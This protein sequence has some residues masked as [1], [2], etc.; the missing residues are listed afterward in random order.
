MTK[1]DLQTF[2][3]V[4]D[5]AQKAGIIAPDAMGLVYQARVSAINL[6][7]AMKDTDTVG[8]IPVDEGE[9]IQLPLGQTYRMPPKKTVQDIE[10]R[11]HARP[12]KSK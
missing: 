3:A 11:E 5:A 1:N 8:I 7:N 10:P 12:D 6:A 4:I 9:L 2:V